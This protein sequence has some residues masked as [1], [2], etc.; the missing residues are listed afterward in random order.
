VQITRNTLDT[1]AGPPDW[2]TGSV[3]IDTIVTPSDASPV[4]SAVVHFTPGAGTAWHTLE[5]GG[6]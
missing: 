2:F 5:D 3:Y 1:R 4:G 6:R